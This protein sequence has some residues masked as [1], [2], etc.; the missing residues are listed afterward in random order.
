[1]DIAAS[2]ALLATNRG[3]QGLYN[4]VEADGTVDSGKVRCLLGWLDG[5]RMS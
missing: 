3:E 1:M 4:V 5:W 2:A